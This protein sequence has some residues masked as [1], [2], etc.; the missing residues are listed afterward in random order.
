MAV[1]GRFRRDPGRHGRAVHTLAE[2]IAETEALTGRAVE[3][4]Y[5][6]KGI[7]ATP[8]PILAASSSRARSA[9]SSALSSTNSGD[10]QPSSP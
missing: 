3:R 4:A 9:A 6:D 7:A 10:A 5:I 2:V 1:S 8:R